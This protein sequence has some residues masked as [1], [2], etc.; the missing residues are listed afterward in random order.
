MAT[1]SEVIESLPKDQWQ[2][3]T[4]AGLPLM[5]TNEL[6]SIWL[7]GSPRKFKQLIEQNKLIPMLKSLKKIL[8]LANEYR[9]DPSMQHVSLTEKLQMAGLS[10]VLSD[11]S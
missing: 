8:Q 2:A 7:E 4:Q 11:K 10:L 1:H 3:L 5:V 6:L 9:A